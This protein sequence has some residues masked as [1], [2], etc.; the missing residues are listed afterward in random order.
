[1]KGKKDVVLVMMLVLALLIS[2]CSSGN[3]NGDNSSSAEGGSKASG[4]EKPYEVH[5]VFVGSDQKDIKEVQDAISAISLEKINATVK[6]TVINWG[7]W[8][9]QTTLMIA[10]NEK[11][12]LLMESNTLFNYSTQVAKGQLLPIDDLLKSH[13]QGIIDS[14]GDEFL[15][16]AKVDGK[17]YGVPSLRDMA[18]DYGVMIV[19]EVAV[20]NNIDTAD[21][22]TLDDL[23]KAYATVKA[24][25]PGVIPLVAPLG[26]I[27]PL[28]LLYPG[29]F[30]LLSDSLGV[31]PWTS[32]DTKIVNMYETTEYQDLVK[33]AR[34]WNEAGYIAKDA[35][36]T[37]EDAA[38]LVKA[39]K[40]FSNFGGMKP[41]IESQ[42]F[43]TS[44]VVHKA[45]ELFPPVYTTG[46]VSSFMFSVPQNS[47]NP[48]K[49]IEFLNLMYTDKDIINLFH[50]GIEGKH[51]K[52]VEGNIIDYPEGVNAG[53]SGF[54][55]SQ[56]WLFGN[57]YLAHVWTGNPTDIWEQTKA[58]N[59]GA[60]KSK[61]FGFV[62][63]SEPVKTE[64][65]SVQNVV[66]QFKMGL[67]T[68]S[69]D[70]EK[71]LPQFIAQLK[72]A[73]I[74]TIITEKQRQ[75]DEWLTKQ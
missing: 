9:Q 18:V 25:E 73:G 38:T 42:L 60:T 49:A 13:G 65:A 23:E 20:R 29:Y 27:T 57:S 66:S 56:G 72:S 61:A 24:N 40:A 53:N 11:M 30:D 3:G 33:R 19:D 16:A 12:D 41:G 22:K 36:T 45:V 6:F 75:M 62:Y 51:Y 70:P 59:D 14:V 43:L 8:S 35:S 1:M 2:A 47:E 63:N 4:N 68:G 44:G 39:G 48:E 7:A 28:E 10:G 64:V 71:V 32:G 55:L 15:S 34:K 21:I 67:E 46:T 58:F 17:T 37:K 5:M 31:L 26:G 54:N 69:V 50:Y 52:I 74:D